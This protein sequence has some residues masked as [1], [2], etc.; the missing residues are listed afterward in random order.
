[1]SRFTL[2][3]REHPGPDKCTLSL[4]A[5]SKEELVDAAVQHASKVHG[6]TDS[7]EVRKQI[8]SMIKVA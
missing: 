7:P 6:F 4:S 1:M 2:D 5:D 3:C 8:G